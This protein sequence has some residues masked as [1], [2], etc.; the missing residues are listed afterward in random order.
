[1]STFDDSDDDTDSAPDS[2]SSSPAKTE[3]GEC[4]S[5]FREIVVTE[6]AFTTYRALLV[7]LQTEHLEF[8]PLLS[9]FNDLSPPSEVTQRRHKKVTTP[10]PDGLSLPLPA[11]PKSIYRLAHL[12]SLPDLS[13]QALASLSSQLT[14]S[15]VLYELFDSV[16][17]AYDEVQKLE[18]AYAIKHW[19]EVKGS[20]AMLLAE[21]RVELGELGHPV[22]MLLQLAKSLN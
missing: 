14:P 19:K 10:R 3:E 2:I 9:S 6:T 17:G 1:M 22:G 21:K 11:S 13:A 12:L 18:L 16:S 15:N 4:G 20:P 5:A 7:Y 8:A